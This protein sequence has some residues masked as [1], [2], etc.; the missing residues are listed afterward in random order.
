VERIL[1]N[2]LDQAVIEYID[3]NGF[4]EVHIQTN[5]PEAR[6]VNFRIKI[7]QVAI[8]AE[9]K[10]DVANKEVIKFFKKLTKK[11]VEIRSGHKARRKL[12]KF[13]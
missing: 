13:T 1:L 3:K 9:P 6:I 12:L 10:D 4:L 7:A 2:E 5:K 11:E 8:K